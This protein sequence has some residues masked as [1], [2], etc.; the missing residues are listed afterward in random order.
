MIDY[1]RF[2]EKTQRKI[3]KLYEI[4]KKN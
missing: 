4:N 3:K 1:Q 2:D